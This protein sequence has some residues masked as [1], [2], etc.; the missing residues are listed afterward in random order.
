MPLLAGRSLGW[1]LPAARADVA[2]LPGYLLLGGATALV[3]S[4]LAGLMRA[5]FAD[6]VR[7]PHEE[8]AWT[9]GLRAARG[10]ALGGLVGGLLFTVVMVQIGFLSDVA[11]LVGTGSS[12][13]GCW[14]TWPS[15]WP[16]GSPTGCCFGAEATT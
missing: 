5:L 8:G 3:L 9:R 15:P 4:W 6:D 12:A 16:S 14:C 11:R 1:S 2:I 13:P 7:R 10:R